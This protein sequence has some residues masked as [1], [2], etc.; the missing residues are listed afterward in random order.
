ME[1]TWTTRSKVTW[2]AGPLGCGARAGKMSNS[3][4]R[5]G[6]R[7]RL[8][9]YQLVSGRDLKQGRRRLAALGIL[10]YAAVQPRH[11]VGFG[12]HRHFQLG[13]G[14][15]LQRLNLP[16]RRAW[17]RRLSGGW[18]RYSWRCES[19]HRRLPRTWRLSP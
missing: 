7:R 3:N 17:H 12:E 1:I 13:V 6:Q 16:M 18:R 2:S 5:T 14:P 10:A 8:G 9:L 4:A 11:S 15:D 19:R